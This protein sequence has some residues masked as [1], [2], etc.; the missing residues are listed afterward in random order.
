MIVKH[1]PGRASG[2]ET[3]IRDSPVR[4]LARAV[5]FDWTEGFC[6]ATL[7]ACAFVGIADCSVERNDFSTAWNQ[8][9]QSLERCL[10]R[11]K[12][13]VDVGVIELDRSENDGIGEIMQELRS[14][15]EECGVVFVA[16]ENEVVDIA[17]VKAGAEILG[18]TADQK[19][20]IE[21]GGVEYPRKHGSRGG[22]AMR[23]RDDQDFFV[24]Q[25]FVVQQLWQ[26]AKWDSLIENM[27]QFDV[28]AGHG[29]A[30]YNQVWARFDIPGVERLCD[31][32]A[33]AAQEVG[34][35]R[36]RGGVGSGDVEAALLQH[37][38][39]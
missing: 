37:S 23:S 10:D 28:A 20:R 39:E 4:T 21:S 13:L 30:D 26:R 38:R 3:Q 31:R 1:G 11:V 14:L 12:I 24:S 8:V 17:E 29:V 6:E 33:Q 19:R 27:L 36:V 2:I 16:L 9:H 32:D 18:D 7:Q 5:T 15:V 35:R 25:E 22:L 34:H